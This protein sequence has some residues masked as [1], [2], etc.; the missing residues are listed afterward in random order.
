MADCVPDPVLFGPQNWEQPDDLPCAKQ[1]LGKMRG[2]KTKALRKEDDAFPV[3]KI[4]GVIH[5]AHLEWSKLD[6]EMMDHLIVVGNRN[7]ANATH[8]MLRHNPNGLP[9]GDTDKETIQCKKA[10]V[11][12]ARVMVHNCQKEWIKKKALNLWIEEFLPKF[13]PAISPQTSSSR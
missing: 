12:I 5:Q 4:N 11:A 7:R 8:F 10:C 1:L 6:K 9:N 3:A 13:S 2:A